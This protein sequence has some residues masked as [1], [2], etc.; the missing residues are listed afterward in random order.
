M[1]RAVRAK[2]PADPQL[3]QLSMATGDHSLLSIKPDAV[4]GFDAEHGG[5][6]LLA[7]IWERLRAEFAA[8]PTLD[9]M[10]VAWDKALSPPSW[11]VMASELEFASGLE[12]VGVERNDDGCEEEEEWD[13]GEG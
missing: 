10:E 2:C 11:P 1:E 13:G 6:N 7:R 8:A 4:R 9:S 5:L 12:F 3:V